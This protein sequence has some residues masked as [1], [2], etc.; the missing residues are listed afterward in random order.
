MS[1]FL[2]EGYLLKRNHMLRWFDVTSSAELVALVDHGIP[3]D[4]SHAWYGSLS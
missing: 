3:A 4:Y 1:A 2:R